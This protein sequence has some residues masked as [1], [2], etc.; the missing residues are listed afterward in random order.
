MNRLSDADI[1]LAARIEQALAEQAAPQAPADLETRV[2]AAIERRASRPW[3]RRSVREWPLPA[4]LGF[5][6]AGCAVVAALLLVSPGSGVPDTTANAGLGS[7]LVHHIP[8]YHPVASTTAS[9]GHALKALADAIPAP[10]LRGGLML[11][12]LAYLAL[13]GLLAAAFRLPQAFSKE[14]R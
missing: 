7:A 13:F 4:R 8:L 14:P 9:F 5:A 11:G 1:R 6:G 3:W 10:A 2:F 12:A